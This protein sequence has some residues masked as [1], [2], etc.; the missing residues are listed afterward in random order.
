M[1]QQ[2]IRKPTTIKTIPEA[3]EPTSPAAPAGSGAVGWTAV[4]LVVMTLAF[5]TL[6]GWTAYQ[7]YWNVNA[8]AKLAGKVAPAW[9][10]ASPASLNGLYAKKAVLVLADGTSVTGS[11]AI[12]ATAR[13]LGPKYTM[14][15]TDIAA[16]PDGAYATLLYHYAGKGSGQGVAVLR[17]NGG[18]IVRQWNY[19]SIETKAP[20][21]KQPAKVLPPSPKPAKG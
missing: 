4:A 9:D 12:I 17:I 14:T 3:A 8:S 15:R 18:K 1:A 13:A 16:T 20:A 19:E 11:K 21:P 5:L 6:A 2:Q 7:R 10:A